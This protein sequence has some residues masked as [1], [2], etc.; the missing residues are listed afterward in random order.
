M[1]RMEQ[2]SRLLVSLA[3]LALAGCQPVQLQSAAAPREVT[4]LA[5]AGQDVVAIN[6]FFPGTIRIRAGDTITWQINS[7]DF[8]TFMGQCHN[9]P[10]MGAWSP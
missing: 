8:G 1:K 6:A 7:F 2:G 4:V 5:G 9:P 3:L 10:L